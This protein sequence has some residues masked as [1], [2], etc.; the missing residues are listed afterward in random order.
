MVTEVI[1]QYLQVTKIIQTMLWLTLLIT[2]VLTTFIVWGRSWI[3]KNHE[4]HPDL[5]KHRGAIGMVLYIIFNLG[6]LF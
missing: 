5:F 2:V 1:F 6:D 3:L 4:T